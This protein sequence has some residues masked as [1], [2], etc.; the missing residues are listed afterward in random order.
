[1]KAPA[2]NGAAECCASRPAPRELPGPEDDVKE[3][4]ESSA[5]CEEVASAVLK[6]KPGKAPPR[7]DITWWLLIVVSVL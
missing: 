1:M 6:M 5:L 2:A 4:T 7:A 3:S